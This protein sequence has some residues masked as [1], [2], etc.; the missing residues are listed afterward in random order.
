MILTETDNCTL[1]IAQPAYLNMRSKGNSINLGDYLTESRQLNFVEY[2]ELYIPFLC[3]LNLDNRKI[4]FIANVDR[5]DTLVNTMEFLDLSGE[6][7][8]YINL[9]ENWQ[10]CFH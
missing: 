10:F 6:V 8:T 7:Y 5:E 9:Q 1:K 3:I 2:N 4:P